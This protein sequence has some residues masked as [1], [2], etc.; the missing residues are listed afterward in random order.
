MRHTY[1]GQE[2]ELEKQ[3]AETGPT[4][5]LVVRTQRRDLFFSSQSFYCKTGNVAYFSTRLAKMGEICHRDDSETVLFA[6]A[7]T[8]SY[9]SVND[10]VHVRVD[11]LENVATFGPRG[12]I[13]NT[14][15]GLGLGSFALS[16][17]IAWLQDNHPDASVEPGKLSSVDAKSEN[18]ERRHRFYAGR[19]FQVSYS[20]DEGDGRFWADKATD[21]IA[22][23]DED[24][25]TV[26]SF[27]QY[28]RA[29]F[30]LCM[31]K[32]ESEE[33]GQVLAKRIEYLEER[34]VRF[35]QYWLKRSVALNILVILV[36][37][38]LWQ[39]GIL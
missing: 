26:L 27:S 3:A 7:D 10:A 28:A 23:Y 37:L 16:R 5:I 29:Y 33:R 39:N 15:P 32:A 6:S 18:K 35:L 1:F 24:K 38:I 2:F 12:Q 22:R 4:E 21:L 17:V 19:G 20:N 13:K 14:Q 8:R 9:S 25:V 30:H 34:K 31:E 36:P 11:V